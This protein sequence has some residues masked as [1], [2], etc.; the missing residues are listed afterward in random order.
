MRLVVDTN[1]LVSAFLW[2]GTPGRLIDL[3]GAKW[4]TLYSSHALLNELADVLHRNKFAKQV[5]ATGLTAAQMIQNYRRLATLVHAP[6]LASP[7][8]RDAGDDVVLA[9]G[10]ASG[11][12]AIVSGDDDLLDLKVFQGIPIVT[13]AQVVRRFAGK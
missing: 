11:V 7:V 6:S 13:A 4:V 2:R 9:C 8:S 10:F 12:D 3:A 5:A 1:V